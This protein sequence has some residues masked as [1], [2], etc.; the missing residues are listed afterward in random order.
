MGGKDD[1]VINPAERIEDI[2]Q[3]LGAPNTHAVRRVAALRLGEIRVLEVQR[4]LSILE[5]HLMAEA[6]NSGA[7]AVKV[8]LA[9]LQAVS[10]IG[11]PSN[12]YASRLVENVLVEDCDKGMR[13]MAAQVQK[14]WDRAKALELED[15]TTKFDDGS[16]LYSESTMQLIKES[17]PEET[18]SKRDDP[19]MD[20][21]AVGSSSLSLLGALESGREEPPADFFPV[22]L[23]DGH[24][25]ED[26]SIEYELPDEARIREEAL[27]EQYL[28]EMIK[29]DEDVFTST[30]SVRVSVKNSFLDF[31]ECEPRLPL[32]RHHTW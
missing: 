10:R 30:S 16:S 28:E 2:L 11:G 20:E 14:D 1:S 12:K 17:W 15:S 7:E 26:L 5:G 24:E 3:R 22:K 8:R 27:R 31:E 6:D 18:A 23:E 19:D 4:V 9:M 32:K 13:Y 25:D 29:H 21:A